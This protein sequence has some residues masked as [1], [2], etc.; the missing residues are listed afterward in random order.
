MSHYM[1]KTDEWPL[2]EIKAFKLSNDN[3]NDI[4]RMCIGED[5]IIMDNFSSRIVQSDVMTFYTNPNLEPPGL[6]ISFR[7]YMMSYKALENSE[8]YEADRN[9]WLS[10]LEDFPSAPA[11]PMRCN[12]ADIKAPRFAR[13]E[14]IFTPL[15]WKRLKEMASKNNITPSV[16]LCTVYA[17]VLAY[18]SNQTR[19]P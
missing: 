6:D 7:D 12:P 17:E 18:W 11:L 15:Q 14:E 13:L 16:L 19:L 8:I 4:Y 5:R 2:F 3:S 10:L 9:Y 1:F